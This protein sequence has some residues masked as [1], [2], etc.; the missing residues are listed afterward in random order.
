MTNVL[1]NKS[2]KNHDINF[3]ELTPANF[4]EA[5]EILIPKVLEEHE[6]EAM[7]AGLTYKE[8]FDSSKQQE[9]LGAVLQYLS[10]VN[11]T[12]QT[13]EIREVYEEY[14]PKLMAIFQ[15]FSVDERI[16]YKLG[17]YTNTQDFKDLSDIKKKVIN[18]I[19]FTFEIEGVALDQDKKDK[20]KEIA[21]KVTELQTQ[22]SNNLVNTQ[23]SLAVELTKSELVGLPER[24]LKNLTEIVGQRDKEGIY[25]VSYVSGLFNDILTY[26]VNDETRKKVYEAQLCIGIKDGADNRPLLSHIATLHHE[27]AQILGYPNFA[28][29][30]MIKNMVTDPDYALHFI[31]SLG[32]K[33]FPQAQK[34]TAEVEAFGLDL[35]NK[36]LDFEDRAFV[37]DKMKTTLLNL[38]E[39]KIR[40][41]FPVDT[42]VKGLFDIIENIYEIKFVATHHSLWHEDVRGYDVL[43][44]NT[45]EKN[46]SLYMDIYKREFK[47][48]GAWMNGVVSRKVTEIEG[49]RLPVAYVVCNAPKDVGQV[50]TFDFDEIVTL[51]HEMGH[52]LHHLL[53]KV[54]DSYFSGINH[55]QHDAV[56]LP[57]QFMENFCWDYE[58]LKKISSHTQTGEHLPKDLFDTMKNA[59]NFLS[60][61]QML[62]QAIFSKVDMVI[63]S[64]PESDPLAVEQ[65]VFKKWST[66]ELDSRAFFLPTFSHIFAGGYSAGYYAY[67]WAEVLSSDAFAALKE[68]GT[69]YVE[70]K[71]AAKK[72]RENIL[73]TGGYKDMNENF[74]N[75]RGRDPDIKYLLED[76]GIKESELVN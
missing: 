71:E 73:E 6:Y 68:S 56:E 61:N 62:R 63:Y 35:L 42:V 26:A 19:L 65:E 34:E 75:F 38:D 32:E 27:Q 54:N 30:T 76:Y 21:V 41:Y 72:F 17:S 11:S 55:V 31:N 29:F 45:N 51:F 60:A 2:I 57:S 12:V 5:F 58:V 50:S 23:S 69:T 46:G 8:L 33:S 22:F 70:Q 39:E 74:F 3:S 49:V 47:N 40:Q 44:V 9:Q 16:Y 66:R 28:E 1:L 18:T 36:K 48:S 14:I 53:T 59:K 20:L 4:R 25:K 24:A 37:I 52:A 43:D 15:D 7:S 64:E 10:H 67:K 13:P